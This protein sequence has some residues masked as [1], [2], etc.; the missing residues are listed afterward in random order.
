[1]IR[2]Y[3]PFLPWLLFVRVSLLFAQAQPSP[4]AS[5]SAAPASPYTL[6]DDLKERDID[7]QKR[8]KD[9]ELND[10]KGEFNK[11]D[12]TAKNLQK[13]I[14]AT[15]ELIDATLT[16][17]QAVTLEAAKFKILADVTD[18][19]ATADK[20]K[21]K[22]LYAL[23]AAQLKDADAL[24]Q[25]IKELYAQQALLE[26][27]RDALTTSPTPPSPA[28]SP[29]NKKGGPKKGE[30]SSPFAERMAARE[31]TSIDLTIAT[32]AA[33]AAHAE[34]SKKLEAADLATVKANRAAIDAG[35]AT[36]ADISSGA[37]KTATPSTGVSPQPTATVTP[38]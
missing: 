7:F 6:L 9:K 26:F 36:D 13:G 21:I 20:Q 37:N 10:L 25:K 14:E 27:E 19:R 11:A 34:A 1:M 22:A 3:L 28:A 29:T 30:V 15:R 12:E 35:L 31:K 4:T 18:L 38:Q 16:N 17:L 32:S 2:C 5:P 24:K 23:N 33:E 8:Q